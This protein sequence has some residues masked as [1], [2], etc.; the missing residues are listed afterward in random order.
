[1]G[2]EE[3]GGEKGK[4]FRKL[5]GKKSCS[6]KERKRRRELRKRRESVCIMKKGE[7]G[8]KVWQAIVNKKVGKESKINEENE[9]N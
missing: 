8:I 7:M 6:E 3:R 1:M 5:M 9:G 4:E 2:G